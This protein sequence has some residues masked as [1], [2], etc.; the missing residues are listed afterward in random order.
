MQICCFDMLREFYKL[1]PKD[2]IKGQVCQKYEFG[3]DDSRVSKGS[4][5]TRKVAQASYLAKVSKIEAKGVRPDLIRLLHCSALNCLGACVIKTQNQ[6]N[7]FTKLIFQV[8][9][10]KGEIGWENI[11]DTDKEWKFEVSTNF[12]SV[13]KAIG[14]IRVE[15][16]VF[17]VNDDLTSS[18]SGNDRRVIS[19]KYL[20]QSSLSSSEGGFWM[21]NRSAADQGGNSLG[22]FGGLA[23][24]SE[25]ASFGDGG[26]DE[27]LGLFGKKSSSN[28][29]GRRSQSKEKYE[30]DRINCN[31]CMP[32]ILEVIDCLHEQFGSK[33]NAPDQ[34]PAWMKTM[35]DGLLDTNHHVNVRLFLGKIIQ[36]R[37]AVFAPYASKIV[38]PLLKFIIT[39][40]KDAGAGL[41]YYFRDLCVM[42]LNFGNAG[43]P[44]YKE[45]RLVSDFMSV[46]LKAVPSEDRTICKENVR[47]F[48]F[49]YKHW[50][51][52]FVLNKGL[53]NTLLMQSKGKASMLARAVGLQIVSIIIAN[54]KLA[55]DPDTDED[56]VNGE[57]FYKTLLTCL[58]FSSKLV[59][60]AGAEVSGQVMQSLNERRE[61]RMCQSY[62][63]NIE[64]AL[65][66]QIDRM[67]S[68]RQYDRALVCLEQIALSYN[69]FVAPYYVRMCEIMT[70]LT[71]DFKNTAL[72]LIERKADEIPDLTKYLRGHFVPILDHRESRTQFLMLK[73]IKKLVPKMENDLL[74]TLLDTLTRNFPTH[75]NV[76]CRR[77]AQE[78]FIAIW[79]NREAFRESTK[80]RI[81]LLKG[82][83]DPE[84]KRTLLSNFQYSEEERQAIEKHKPISEM[85]R[86]FW[87]DPRRLS[88]SSVARLEELFSTLYEPEVESEW[89]SF[90][91]TMLMHLCAKSQAYQSKLFEH[92]LE[93][94]AQFVDVNIDTG[95]GIATNRSLA[96]TPSST[97]SS[98]VSGD[99]NTSQG[100]AGSFESSFEEYGSMD[101]FLHIRA[102]NQDVRFTPTMESSLKFTSSSLEDTMSGMYKRKGLQE[103]FKKPDLP[104]AETVR[105][106]R[107]EG[108]AQENG[109]QMFQQSSQ[110][111][112]EKTVGNDESMFVRFKPS[113]KEMSSRFNL[114]QFSRS[115]KKGQKVRSLQQALEKGKV[116]LLRKYRMGEVPNIAI[117]PE[118]FLEPLNV[119]ASRDKTM[120]AT[121][122]A[123]I[124]DGVISAVPSASR[125]QLQETLSGLISDTLNRSSNN[126]AF[127][128]CLL[129]ICAL[130][131]GLILDDKLVGLSAM[132]SFSYHT[133]ALLLEKQLESRKEVSKPSVSKRQKRREAE[134]AIESEKES[135]D[136]TAWKYL[137]SLYKV[138]GDDDVLTGVFDTHLAK[139]F[140]TH[141]AIKKELD[142]DYQ[143]A[144]DVYESGREA[145]SDESYNWGENGHPSMDEVDLWEDG[146][147]ECLQRLIK[148]DDLCE[149]TKAEVDGS[150]S[151]LWVAE[152]P[153]LQLYLQSSFRC[154]DQWGDLL[155][156]VDQ[157][158]QDEDR[159]PVLMRTFGP[160]LAVM[161][162]QRDDFDRAQYFCTQSFGNVLKSWRT[163]HP[164]ARKGRLRLMQSLQRIKEVL[165]V[166]SFV[167]NDANFASMKPLSKL[168]RR[169]ESRWPLEQTSIVVWDSVAYSRN[170]LLKKLQDRFLSFL[171]LQHVA[172]QEGRSSSVVAEDMLEQQYGMQYSGNVASKENVELAISESQI[173]FWRQC[174]KAGMKQKNWA[175]SERFQ[176]KCI[177][178]EHYRNDVRREANLPVIT[179]DVPSTVLL[180]KLFEKQSCYMKKQSDKVSKISKTIQY[181]VN[182]ND[183]TEEVLSSIPRN[184]IMYHQLTCK[185]YMT[186]LTFIKDSNSQS[187]QET[188]IGLAQ[189][190]GVLPEHQTQSFM[191]A[192]L[193]KAYQH[194]NKAYKAANNTSDGLSP[195][196]K[197]KTFLKMAKFCDAYIEEHGE[198]KT[199]ETRANYAKHI[200]E[201]ILQA[202]SLG[203]REGNDMLPKILTLLS[204]N[205]LPQVG[206]CISIRFVGR[207]FIV[208]VL[209]IS[210]YS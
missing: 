128:S 173:K 124:I 86:D 106:G 178:A 160:E 40:V 91:P 53:V 183:F 8:N 5:L 9:S 151:D 11:V 30:F 60:S 158:M 150:L 190:K 25:G 96:F 202:V 193:K 81:A 110:G 131:N 27:G 85:V 161:S 101:Q 23:H 10:R 84:E 89:L 143:G 179:A 97:L 166:V 148:W 195:E 135:R 140:F 205:R 191:N 204:N 37:E 208:L 177:E 80:L 188:L 19:E 44:D 54:G 38:V 57:E 78:I 61:D 154:P 32:T 82:L 76:D 7:F 210:C 137:G 182:K 90:A 95:T 107:G 187:E 141:D 119:I 58:D 111:V 21:S 88:E 51:D 129:R 3:D 194:L 55:Y 12:A 74:N 130:H 134:A 162:V 6:E 33:Y 2:N 98:V 65:H 198:A 47:L 113:N 68:K 66:K 155:K 117:T 39:D 48:R 201:A 43:K 34:M 175:V 64:T 29:M 94:G 138:L 72:F 103:I 112:S 22:S 108:S 186:L 168:L 209:I 116:P 176:K 152:E 93:A 99:S 115:Q 157:G 185:I 79:E 28:S 52:R 70:L 169:W 14:D 149:V 184:F 75:N 62:L 171:K 49:F 125:T 56:S 167:R 174:T 197:A 4:E 15:N 36:M 105:I 63:A 45:T 118:E 147:L 121:L 83:S 77:V 206:M 159:A 146:R 196:F 24:S 181:F 46:L 122:L 59:Y 104:G 18:S 41:H 17:Q 199:N 153:Y 67:F 144:L 203:S 123:I 180:I 207:L 42:L 156:F 163:L 127:V 50:K 35:V 26:A 136:R 200:I 16:D 142:G 102:T 87:N 192:V 109:N 189:Q 133:G 13:R 71:G 132:K 165:E 31:P 20:E 164:L 114:V 172:I 92:A 73:I 69:D 100:F 145:A 1:V 120:A 126:G 170:L 139:H